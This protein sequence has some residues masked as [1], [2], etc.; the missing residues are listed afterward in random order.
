MK[1]NI[2]QS[3]NFWVNILNVV[4]LF[5][6][7]SG[8]KVPDGTGETLVKHL[9]SG[10]LWAFALALLINVVTPIYKLVKNKAGTWRASL[11]STNFWGQVASLVIWTLTFFG[12]AIPEGTD[13]QI[14]EL[15]FSQNW[16]QLLSVLIINII[17][18]L[19]H[20]FG[21]KLPPK[22]EQTAIADYG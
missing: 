1:K 13:M 7:L 15:I 5:F 14:V 12:A 4:L 6:V 3:I 16:A 19:I 9:F 17:V 10:N 8:A 22:P 11:H 18:P 21:L 2:F 20:I